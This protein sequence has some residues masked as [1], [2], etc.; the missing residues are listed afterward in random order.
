MAWYSGLKTTYY[1]RSIAATTT[2][3]STINQGSLNAV[4]AQ[5]EAKSE[6]PQELGTPAP[7]PEACSLDDPDCE[8]CQ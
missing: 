8:A 3:K 6:A 5:N 7:V 4:S 1:L 2:E